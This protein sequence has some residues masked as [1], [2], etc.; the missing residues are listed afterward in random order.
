MT[1]NRTLTSKQVWEWNNAIR[2]LA[3]SF[4]QRAEQSELEGSHV[5]GEVWRRAAGELRVQ[6]TILLNKT[7][8]DGDIRG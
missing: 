3:D 6:S 8:N 4:S 5:A 7:S 2:R 1:D